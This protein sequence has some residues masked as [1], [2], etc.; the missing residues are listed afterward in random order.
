[1]DADKRAEQFS[2]LFATAIGGRAPYAWQ[3]ALALRDSWPS[4]LIAM[5]GSGKTAG[6]TLAWL[7]RRSW[8]PTL[9]PRRLV[10]CLPMRTLVEQTAEAIMGWLD[11]IAA[12]TQT[13]PTDIPR[14]TD[15]HL[16][17]GGVEAGAWLLGVD[18]PAILI[19]TQDMLISR[20]LNRGYAAA[21]HQ[22]PMEFALLHTDCLWIMD[23]VQLMGSGLATTTQLQGL[24]DRWAT[25]GQDQT[26]MAPSRSLWVSATLDPA[27][28]ATVDHPAPD[29][30]SVMR[31][32]P[33]EDPAL[34]R[35]AEAQKRI[36][37]PVAGPIGKAEKDAREYAQRLA[38]LAL[39]RHR[40]GALT[41]V[42]V[43]TVPRAQAVHGALSKLRTQKSRPEILMIHS[44]FRGRERAE[45]LSQLPRPGEGRDMIIVATQAIEAGV[46]ISAAVLITE[47]APWS[48]LVQRL[49]RA[50]RYAEH[51]EG[52]EVHCIDLWHETPAT[53]DAL[54]LPYTVDDLAQARHRLQALPDAAPTHLGPPG[55]L[56]PP[57]RV[58]R[59][60][61][62]MDLFDTDPDL[63][64]FD[65]DISAYVRDNQD[66][67]LQVAWVDI[68]ALR[69]GLAGLPWQPSRAQ[70][71]PVPIGRAREWWKKAGS[72]DALVRDPQ[73]STDEQALKGWRRL[74]Q[75]ETLYPG[76]VLVVPPSAG[77]YC[78]QRGFT[79]D[80]QDIPSNILDT[81]PEIE[82]EGHADDGRSASGAMVT[83]QAH[84]GHVIDEM[85]LLGERLGLPEAIVQ[86]LTSAATWHDVGKAH[87]VFQ[88][89]MRQ[90][91]DREV[92][93]EGV[94]LAKT[95]GTGL[96]HERSFFRHELAS[97]LAWLQHR[98][99][100]READLIAYLIAAHH[101]K[102]RMSLRALPREQGPEDGRRF[103][104][105]VWEGDAVP[106][107]D[108]GRGQIWA[109]G[110]LTLS[111]MEL[112]LDPVT[113]E[114]WTERAQDLLHRFGPFQLSLLET[115]LRLADWRASAAESAAARALL[116]PEA[117][118]EE[119]TQHVA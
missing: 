116:Q 70:L 104:R 4:T 35:L 21:R 93:A 100:A 2:T 25:V 113:G 94:L 24:R 85:R 44:R 90:G 62:L 13:Y 108:L 10:W 32:E 36:Q 53:R 57:R 17:L 73:S 97:A 65:V 112:G 95:K 83:L 51:A 106:A 107:V 81:V 118:P 105:G 109:G 47:L 34:Q 7:A 79:G 19:G 55:A 89:T 16:L 76:L 50:N 82:G 63:T 5:T 114:S 60:R 87:P 61:D 41:L 66:T 80:L 78:V 102:V 9:T 3:T 22:W 26:I 56:A 71:C 49:G 23:E 75:N 111:I 30:K 20:A 58:I 27:W 11:R 39:D 37:D 45:Q 69:L 40:P 77:G 29:P 88:A 12:G 38:Q 68:D 101:G 54:A 48:S 84:T 99:W 67:D 98:R 42:I 91:L 28:L 64:G 14:S 110:A 46:D 43:N 8:E 74:R 92:V 18:R 31:V 59:H 52:A 103:A 96:R 117:A 115:L 119:G 86:V 72:R 1:M 15:V 33:A 6:I